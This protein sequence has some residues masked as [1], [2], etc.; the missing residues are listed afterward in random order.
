MHF[1]VPHKFGKAEA[2]RRV[3][4][5]LLDAKV[6]GGDQI[7]INEERWDGDTLNFDFTAQGQRISGAVVVTDTLLDITA[8]LPLMY[9]LFEGRIEAAIKEQVAKML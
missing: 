1:E 4:T 5:A 9:R 2:V 7:K 8:K 6:K 3:K